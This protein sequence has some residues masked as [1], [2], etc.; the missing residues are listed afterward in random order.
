MA[1]DDTTGRNMVTTGYFDLCFSDS[2]NLLIKIKSL[3]FTMCIRDF[4]LLSFQKKKL[5]W[6]APNYLITWNT[7]THDVN[8]R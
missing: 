6:L 4:M 8:A 5:L 1:E 2:G 7:Q 3:Y